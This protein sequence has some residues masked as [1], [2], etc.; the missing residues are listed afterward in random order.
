[1]GWV[2]I[3]LWV[4]WATPKWPRGA[5][6]EHLDARAIP[7]VSAASLA[8][9]ISMGP[10][11]TPRTR[12]GFD[13]TDVTG[14]TDALPAREPRWRHPSATQPDQNGGL[15]A[16]RRLVQADVG[17]KAEKFLALAPTCMFLTIDTS[18]P[19]MMTHCKPASP[20]RRCRH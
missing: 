8:L 15:W 19:A 12:N 20:A 7:D 16:G 17:W 6:T 18:A 14:R 3:T 10:G 1:M 13:A 5:N 9:A 11:P 2:T 4:V